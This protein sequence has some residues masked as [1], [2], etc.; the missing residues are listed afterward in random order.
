MQRS[1][2]SAAWQGP[3]PTG[4]VEPLPSLGQ[5]NNNNNSR[6]PTPQKTQWGGQV[7]PNLAPRREHLRREAPLFHRLIKQGNGKQSAGAAA[8]ATTLYRS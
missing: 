1:R 2:S 7:V 8:G 5:D 4:E 6:T 3:P